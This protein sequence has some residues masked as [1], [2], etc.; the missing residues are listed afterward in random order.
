MMKKYLLGAMMLVGAMTYAQGNQVIVPVD[1]TTGNATANI[2]IE[3]SGKVFDPTVKS[4][5]VEIKSS[6]TPDG[7]G[8]AFQMPDLFTNNTSETIV[9]KFTAKV[10]S[11]AAT[12]GKEV[13]E[14]LEKPIITKLVGATGEIAEGTTETEASGTAT[15]TKI[16]YTLTG[17]SVAGDLEH[18]GTLAVSV[19]TGNKV[20][21]YVDNTVG[22]RVKL[23]GQ[24]PG[25]GE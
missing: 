18:N 4:L 21:T 7:K 1:T 19:T 14:A 25:K 6:A 17:T 16:N 13:V 11:N 8:F 22:L 2:G 15:G 3:V 12:Q 24:I 5:V 23:E 9:G 20:G 10:V